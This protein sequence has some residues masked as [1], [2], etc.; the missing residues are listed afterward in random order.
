MKA[1]FTK[2]AK[3][4]ILNYLRDDDEFTG[5]FLEYWKRTHPNANLFIETQRID[6]GKKY[7]EILGDCITSYLYD[8]EYLDKKYLDISWLEIQQYGRTVIVDLDEIYALFKD[9]LQ[10]QEQLTKGE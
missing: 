9:Y 8:G 10:E 6:A 1:K 5:L 4:E 7:L 2:N 3:A